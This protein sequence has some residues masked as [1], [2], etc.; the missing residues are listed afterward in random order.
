[1]TYSATDN[2]AEYATDDRAGDGSCAAAGCAG[3]KPASSKNTPAPI[4]RR[5]FVLPSGSPPSL[6]RKS[7][8]AT[9]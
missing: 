6:D 9:I 7:S 2:A 3:N 8:V 5:I 1:M 4:M